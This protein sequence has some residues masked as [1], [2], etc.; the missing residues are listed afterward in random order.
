ML[1]PAALLHAT[2]VGADFGV[3]KAPDVTAE[4]DA[5]CLV[6]M[7]LISLAWLILFILRKRRVRWTPPIFQRGK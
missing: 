2:F 4:A 6:T 5:G 3:N 1:L 7:S